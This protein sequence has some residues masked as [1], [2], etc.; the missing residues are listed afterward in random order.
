M[1]G[2]LSTMGSACVYGGTQPQVQEC[3]SKLLTEIWHRLVSIEPGCHSVCPLCLCFP[4]EL[5]MT[6][7]D[8]LSCGPRAGSGRPEWRC[9]LGSSDIGCLQTNRWSCHI[10]APIWQYQ[11]FSANNKSCTVICHLSQ[12]G[13]SLWWVEYELILLLTLI[14][15]D[16][17]LTPGRD[18]HLSQERQRDPGSAGHSRAGQ[19]RSIASVALQMATV[20]SC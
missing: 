8:P 3:C 13:L 2:Q 18:R 1:G 16:R 7:S 20:T 19:G 12:R 14:A 15:Q 9:T 5:G 17:R 10:K 11:C 4:T 6:P